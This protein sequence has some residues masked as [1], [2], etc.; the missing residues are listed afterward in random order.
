MSYIK[1]DRQ[2]LV[3]LEYALSKELLR[4]NRAGSYSSTTII[5]C[6][7]RRY[8]G[9]LIT[10]QPLLDGEHHVL[11]SSVDETIIQ[12]NTAFNLGIH[13]FKG[14]TYNPK[15][16]KYIVDFSTEPI[17]KLTF[18]VGGVRLTKEMLFTHS[19]DQMVIKYTLEEAHSPTTLRLKPFFA[20]RNH[21]IL[22]KSN[23]FVNTKYQEIPNGIAVKMYDGY[24]PVFLQ[25]SKKIDYIHVP[26]WYYNIEYTE[27]MERGYDYLEDLY[28]PGYFEFPLKKGE[29]IYLLAGL[30]EVAPT[31]LKKIFEDEVKIRIPRDGFENCLLNSA[32]QFILKRNNK[33]E[34]IAGFPWFGRQGRETFISLPGLTLVDNRIENFK[35]VLKCMVEDMTGPFFPQFKND[36]SCENLA[37]DTQL[38]FFWTLQQYIEFTGDY[39]YVWTE[40]ENILLNILTAYRDKYC[41]SIQLHDNGLLYTTDGGRPM[42]WMNMM[43]KDKAVT[44]RPGYA[45]E[46]NALWYNAICFYIELCKK[47]KKTDGLEPWIELSEKIPSSFFETFWCYERN[48]LYDYSD[49]VYRDWSTRPNQVLAASLPYSPLA[50]DKQKLML[51]KIRSELVTPRGLR[52]LAPKNPLYI[53]VYV[54]NQETRDRATHQGSV[55]PWLIAHFAEAYLK[56]HGKSGLHYIKSLYSGFHDIIQEH[57]IGSISELYDGDPPHR[58]GGAISMAWNVAELLRMHTIIKKYESAS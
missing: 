30:N 1:F 12:Q 13:K 5:G 33:T 10:R 49:G 19:D 37:A 7:T 39:K 46:I 6:N 32:H 40:F 35:A 27:E 31:N 38:W 36:A 55:H 26:D 45:V 57:G 20:F 9:L 14:G 50:E 34:V 3:N 18:Q 16:H 23:I 25:C 51:D 28:V 29:S 52:S 21:H 22:S 4:S 41:Y 58:P 11:L 15:G 44:L 17:P 47:M 53:G 56:I 8:H 24:S 2:L 48:H 42:T 54:G 43:V